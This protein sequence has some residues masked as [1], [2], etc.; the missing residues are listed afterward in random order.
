ML[1]SAMHE[2]SIGG[3]KLDLKLT[4][5]LDKI[6]EFL[7]LMLTKKGKLRILLSPAAKKPREDKVTDVVDR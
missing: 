1:K 6:Y 3:N 2:T 5:M 7:A 4:K